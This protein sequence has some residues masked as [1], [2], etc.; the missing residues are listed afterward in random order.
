MSLD[1]RPRVV[2]HTAL[3][4]VVALIDPTE[5][6]AGNVVLP[7]LGSVPYSI[8]PSF[9][10]STMV[11][12]VPLYGDV[13]IPLNFMSAGSGERSAVDLPLLGEVPYEITLGPPVLAPGETAYETVAGF[14]SSP[15]TWMVAAGAGALVLW[16]LLG[17]R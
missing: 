12:A 15:T 13:A 1:L 8:Y 14:V 16:L 2:F 7:N 9:P 6:L 11:L 4:V 10:A 3:G 5:A 17:K